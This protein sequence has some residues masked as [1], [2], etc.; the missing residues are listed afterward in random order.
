MAW[1]RL[2]D[3]TA[4]QHIR[5]HGLHGWMKSGWRDLSISFD[6]YVD[7]LMR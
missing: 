6:F 4:D 1:D 3:T 7:S 5:Q 2:N